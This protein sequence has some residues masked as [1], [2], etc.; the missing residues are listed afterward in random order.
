LIATLVKNAREG[1]DAG[2]RREA[3]IQLGYEKDPAV[4]P[5]LVKLLKDSNDAVRHAAVI[6]LGRYGDVR[7]IE[8]LIK[9]RIFRSP[10]V[11]IRWAAVSAISK[12]GDYRVVDQLIKA[13][14]DTEWI[15]RNQA[16]TGLK[17]KIHEIIQLRDCRYARI[18]VR[19][20]S[21]ENREIVDLTIEGFQDL[22]LAK[23]EL[24]MGALENPSVLMRRNASRALGLM[25]VRE[26][27][28]PLIRHLTDP[29]WE[30]RQSAVFALG[31][32]QDPKAVEPLIQRIRDNVTAVQQESREALV[33]FGKISVQPLLNALGHEKDKFAQRA[34]IRALGKLSDPK[35]IPALMNLL[36]SSYFVVRMAAVR[37]LS[38][39][40]SVVVEPLLPTLSFNR[41]NIKPLLRDASDMDN[42][43]L[44]LRSIRA[45]GGLEDHRAVGV[46]KSLVDQG[47]PEVQEA[48]TEALVQ[49]G[50]AAWGR[51]GVLMVLSRVGDGNLVSQILPSLEDDS[52]NVRVEAVRAL[53]RIGGP[54]IIEPLTRLARRDSDAY[55]RFEIIRLL[56]TVGVG[57][58]QVLTLALSCLKDTDRGVRS[59][60]ARLLGNFHD[61]RS[62]TPL[63]RRTADTHWS[64]RQSAEN[65]LLN[66][67]K[68][69]VPQLLNALSSRSWTTRFRAARLLGE[70]GDRRAI[71]PLEKLLSKKG[72]REAVR[73]II[74]RS[75]DKL[76]GKFA[77]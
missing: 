42:R 29:E 21:L 59:Q 9:P 34:I 77:A 5:V 54:D 48:A 62:I 66:F 49:I 4:Y 3:I 32:I 13:T 37:A 14:S 58:D 44:Q 71:Q 39:F 73:Q 33:K 2:I 11:N 16:A 72:E 56:R 7:A 36:R 41:S 24:L 65:A 40:G 47:S 18:L 19:L 76:K 30:V 23:C 69:A 43:P 15:V 12:L 31:E 67:G 68:H 64:V 22:G 28:D 57:Y 60:A 8:E 20:L 53:A 35:S 74:R 61:N 63:L 52:N 27:V 38:R 55:I 46:L 17:E 51:C 1:D 26:A 6:S 45:L 25:K 10:V 50:C 70:V 75:L